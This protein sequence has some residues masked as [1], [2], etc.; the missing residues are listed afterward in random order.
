VTFQLSALAE[1][2]QGQAGRA[3]QAVPR[4]NIEPLKAHVH[5]AATFYPA[6]DIPICL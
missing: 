2:M 1:L 6:H 3:S 5:L 4:Q